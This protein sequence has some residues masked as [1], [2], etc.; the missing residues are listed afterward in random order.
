ML[1]CTHTVTDVRKRAVLETDKSKIF[2]SPPKERAHPVVHTPHHILL[3]LKDFQSIC[4]NE[5]R[6]V[7]PAPNTQFPAPD[8]TLPNPKSFSIVHSRHDLNTY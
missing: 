8:T 4:Q 1:P 3:C 5:F 2:I 6:H 7:P